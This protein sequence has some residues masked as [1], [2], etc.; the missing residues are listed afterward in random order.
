[1]G[2][3]LPIAAS[4]LSQAGS[5]PAAAP[6]APVTF[7]NV[8]QSGGNTGPSTAAVIGIAVAAVLVVGGGIFLAMRRA[9]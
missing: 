4:L 7:G 3:L 1:M 5:S 9:K 8:S 6:A 2:S